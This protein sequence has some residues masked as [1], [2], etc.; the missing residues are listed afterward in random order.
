MKWEISSNR[1]AFGWSGFAGRALI[2]GLVLCLMTGREARG[3]GTS[4]D[5]WTSQLS[6]TTNNLNAVIY[7]APNFMAVG[8]GGVVL[9]SP[10]GTNW[11]GQ[12]VGTTNNLYGLV[13]ST[14]GLY[15]AVGARGV[16]FTS[17][18]GVNWTNQ[19]AHLLAALD[20]YGVCQGSGLLVAV[21]IN[22]AIL[23][24][25]DGTNWAEQTTGSGTNFYAVTYGNSRYVAT[26][27][28]SSAL[29][30][31]STNG[32]NWSNS[33]AGPPIRGLLF[34]NGIF[35]GVGGEAPAA[36]G[37]YIATSPDGMTWTGQHSGIISQN[38]GAITWGN[39]F[40]VTVGGMTYSP[41]SYSQVIL[42]SPDA[43]HWTTRLTNSNNQL[44]GVAYGNGSFV[45][46]GNGGMILQSGPIFTI[47]GGSQITNGGYALT[48]TGQVGRSYSIQANGDLT[49]TNWSVVA[50]FTNNAETMQVIDSSAGGTNQRFY[51]A[52]TQ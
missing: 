16:I 5:N 37:G 43:A 47:A 14:N 41:S 50:S 31:E 28:G 34:A 39:G 17:P 15:V 7:N 45:A 49:T 20:L 42:S 24:S 36:L 21:G 51:R 8:N 12:S 3:Q 27:F 26:G 9:V 35:V 11:T 10:D 1:N 13:C 2:A 25:P 46:V 33:A 38:L 18:D 32:T 30:L 52:V 48:L 29:V 40:Y 6:G 44:N 19:T 23:T 4:L 22:H